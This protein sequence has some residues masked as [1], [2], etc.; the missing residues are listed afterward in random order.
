MKKG[1][2]YSFISRDSMTTAGKAMFQ[3]LGV[4]AEFER[5]IICERVMLVSQAR[6]RRE[7]N[8]AGAESNLQ[9]KRA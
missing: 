3:M 7:Q 8:W 2:G 4:F 9:S 1:P 6:G 5:G